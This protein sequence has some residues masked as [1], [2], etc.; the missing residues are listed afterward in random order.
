M[1]TYLRNL[2]SAR[3]WQRLWSREWVLKFASLLIATMLWYFVGGEDIV[4]K[5]VMVPVEIINLPRDLVISNQ[6]KKEIE[7]TVSGPRSAIQEM[8]ERMVTRQVNLSE[9]TPGTNVIENESDSISVPRG[10]TVLRVQPSSIILSID[11]LIQKDF[12]I[13]PFTSGDVAAG[14]EVEKLVMNPEKITI[15]GPETVLSLADQLITEIIDINGL[16]ETKS[17]QVPLDLDPKFVSLIGQTA[18]TAEVVVAPKMVEKKLAKVKVNAAVGGS[19]RE[20]APEHVSVILRVPVLLLRDVKEVDKLF[21]VVTEENIS[22]NGY[23]QVK[24]RPNPANQL[25]LEVV[26][27]IPDAVK[28]VTPE[29]AAPS[30]APVA[31]EP[32][33]EK[34]QIEQVEEK[35]PDEGDIIELESSPETGAGVTIQPVRTKKHKTN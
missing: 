5:N 11:K 28:L 31:P 33:E 13:T 18:V 6:F 21:S 7:V 17:Y 8:A 16:K 25:P 15:T 1:N 29:P 34:E 19:K 26:S 23:L 22:E 27:I 4:D 30:V 10:V 3:K 14:Y 12:P 9:A 35:K 32:V 2:F 24:I 20:V